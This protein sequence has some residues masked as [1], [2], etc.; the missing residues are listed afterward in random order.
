ML[1]YFQQKISQ[2]KVLILSG[3]SCLLITVFFIILGTSINPGNAPGVVDLQLSFSKDSFSNIINQWGPE[4]TQFFK[5]CL[6]IDFLYAFLYALFLS[7]L[8][9]YL[10]LKLN[11]KLSKTDQFFFFLP[12]IAGINDWIENSLH[13]IVLRDMKD[14]SENLIFAASVFASVKWSLVL[15]SILFILYYLFKILIETRNK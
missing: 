5:F 11:K 15:L 1:N 9:A 8:I 3:I 13:L 7:S 14:F 12:I 6:W 10:S 2:K 4:I